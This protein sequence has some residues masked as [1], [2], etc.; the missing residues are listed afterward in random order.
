MAHDRWA[1]DKAMH[2]AK[3]YGLRWTQVG[4]KHYIS[5]YRAPEVVAVAGGDAKAAVVTP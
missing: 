1:N 5:S 3:S 4:L 2:E